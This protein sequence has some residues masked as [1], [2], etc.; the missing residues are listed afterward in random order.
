MLKRNHK[1]Y[2]HLTVVSKFIFCHDRKDP[3]RCKRYNS[4]KYSVLERLFSSTMIGTIAMI[5]ISTTN[6]HL[7]DVPYE[8]KPNN[9]LFRFDISQQST[10]P[11][12]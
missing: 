4:S 7:C 8:Y 12:S 6:L 5:K 3:S 10:S 2:C 11:T 9:V 1:E